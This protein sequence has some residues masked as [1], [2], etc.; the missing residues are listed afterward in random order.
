MVETN[1][2]IQKK[3]QQRRTLHQICIRRKKHH[4]AG[5]IEWCCCCEKKQDNVRYWNYRHKHIIDNY[6]TIRQSFLCEYA[7]SSSERC[8][9]VSSNKKMPH[10]LLLFSYRNTRTDKQFCKYLVIF[11]ICVVIVT[12]VVPMVMMKFKM[13]HTTTTI[14]LSNETMINETTTDTGFDLS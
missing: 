7:Y 5:T 6:Q 2:R 9:W 4:I 14:N 11:T 3:F 12:L 13:N 10:V 1:Y 8:I